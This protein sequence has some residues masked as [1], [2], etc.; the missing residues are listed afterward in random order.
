MDYAVGTESSSSYGSNQG[1]THAAFSIRHCGRVVWRQFSLFTITTL[2][3]GRV[4]VEHAL[5]CNGS[6]EG[7]AHGG[8]VERDYHIHAHY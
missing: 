3:R 5:G 7:I 2:G 1:G 4:V 8:R 6:I